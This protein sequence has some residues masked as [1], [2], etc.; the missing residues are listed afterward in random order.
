MTEGACQV[1][2]VSPPASRPAA[3]SCV[4]IGAALVLP[5]GF[6]QL[7][8]DGSLATLLPPALSRGVDALVFTAGSEE[9]LKLAAL[10]GLCR[11]LEDPAEGRRA[12][13]W[14]G[15]GFA[16]FEALFYLGEGPFATAA[17]LGLAVP[18]H[19]LDGWILGHF[20]PAGPTDRWRRRLRG[21][22][23]V[24]AI[25]GLWDWA[26]ME[27][28]AGAVLPGLVVPAL[29]V[30]QF[31]LAARLAGRQP[32]LA[33]QGWLRDRLPRP[34]P[35][36]RRVLRGLGVVL[37]GMG[38]LAALAVVAGDG[39][40]QPGAEAM[41]PSAE[42]VHSGP[43]AVVGVGL[44]LLLGGLARWAGREPATSRTESP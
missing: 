38:A 19:V 14:L 10:L 23:L 1:A 27:V 43:E 34:G 40:L 8:L 29:F 25:H 7:W 2:P 22:A 15:V 36:A 3:G 32:G 41:A 16:L 26:V 21:L 13:A 33:A 35:T 6:L 12:G 44:W 18:S 42:A 17:R 31:W 4:L 20:V 5:A 24:L 30:F 37:L 11:G 9:G 39:A 28:Q